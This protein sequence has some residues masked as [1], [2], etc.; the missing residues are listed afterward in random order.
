MALYLV[1]Y[2]FVFACVYSFVFTFLSCSTVI[3]N[4]CMA[5]TSTFVTIALMLTLFFGHFETS[6]EDPFNYNSIVYICEQLL[7]L[8]A[9]DSPLTNKP[10]VS[11][12]VTEET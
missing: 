3:L 4:S 11:S 9:L 8:G 10:D 1:N 12:G 6:L 2:F 7:E 5:K